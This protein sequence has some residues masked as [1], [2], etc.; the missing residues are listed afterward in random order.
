MLGEV[1]PPTQAKDEAWKIGR[2]CEHVP[3]VT[4]L[5]VAPQVRMGHIPPSPA[6]QCCRSDPSSPAQVTDLGIAHQVRASLPPSHAQV[7]D[8]GIAR[9]TEGHVQGCLERAISVGVDILITSGEGR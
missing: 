8:L 3:R 6:Q 1:P 9:D 5:G 2:K 7:T 4:G